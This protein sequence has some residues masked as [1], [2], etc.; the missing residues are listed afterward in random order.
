M[1]HGPGGR[2]PLLSDRPGLAARPEFARALLQTVA[3]TG[4][5][6]LYQDTGG[7]VVWSLNGP[8]PWPQNPF[9]GGRSE[10]LSSEASNQLDKAREA[11][12][13][14][15]TRRII[16]VQ[17][18]AGSSIRCFD[19][20]LSADRDASGDILGLITTAVETTDQK[21]REQTLRALLR[22][23]THRS[24]NLL[25]IILSIAG[26]TGHYSGTIETFLLRFRGR[27]QSLASS[28]DLVTLSNWRGADFRQLA[29]SQ[30]GRYCADP[31]HNIGMTGESPYLNPNAALHIGLALHELAVNSVSHGALAH[32]DGRI[33][34]DAQL[35]KEQPRTGLQMVWRERLDLE[36]RPLSERRF[37]SVALERV[38]PTAL[39]G[40]ASLEITPNHV[41]YELFVPAQNY[42]L[43][44]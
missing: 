37:G 22:E 39:D 12:L 27:I 20:C 31:E 40:S 29:K 11:V 19:L 30:I 5:S 23:V 14:T 32:A 42:E 21:R 35:L 24:K 36:N 6:V 44:P 25:A 33:D 34:L 4:V 10:I 15:G 41:R 3:D 26:Q 1:T 16:E 9:G 17:I 2:H 43:T 8:D 7:N 13:E 38:V 28:Q 18:Q